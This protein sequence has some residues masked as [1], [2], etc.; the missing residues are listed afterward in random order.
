MAHRLLYES[1]FDGAAIALMA[2]TYERVCRELGLTAREDRLTEIVA[3]TVIDCMRN[4]RVEARSRPRVC[5]ARVE[6]HR[7]TTVVPVCTHV[8]RDGGDGGVELCLGLPRIPKLDC[9][10]SRACA[11]EIALA[12]KNLAFA[13]AGHCEP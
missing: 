11:S 1:G 8:V 6:H 3:K 13:I 7:L 9:I 10:P 5:P 2:T 12:V 4:N